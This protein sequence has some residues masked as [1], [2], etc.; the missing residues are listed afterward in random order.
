[1]SFTDFIVYKS[2]VHKFAFFVIQVLNNVL[3]HKYLYLTVI[4]L[5]MIIYHGF[6]FLCTQVYAIIFHLMKQ[7][8][9]YT[10]TCM[11]KEVPY[12]GVKADK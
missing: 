7:F 6:G 1:M 11:C 12:L 5:T 9:L 10:N 4:Y 2:I 3:L 8:Y